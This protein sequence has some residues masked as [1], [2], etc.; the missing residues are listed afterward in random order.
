M[1]SKYSC[2][3]LFLHLVERIEIR[4]EEAGKVRLGEQEAGG[5]IL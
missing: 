2:V 3:S 1:N 4:P 5:D